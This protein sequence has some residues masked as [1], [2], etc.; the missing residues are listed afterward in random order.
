[1]DKISI[2]Y[3]FE[4]TSGEKTNVVIKDVKADASPS[5]INA[6]ADEIIEKRGSKNGVAFN[7][8]ATAVKITTTEEII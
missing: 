6:L 2:K 8:L 5:E 1:M 4:L 3:T 7:K